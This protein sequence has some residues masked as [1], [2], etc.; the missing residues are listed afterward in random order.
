MG[1]HGLSAGI[2]AQ[3]LDTESIIESSTYS[4]LRESTVCSIPK[5]SLKCI[6][7]QEVS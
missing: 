5:M 4:N 1:G 7:M 2:L 3:G 6:E